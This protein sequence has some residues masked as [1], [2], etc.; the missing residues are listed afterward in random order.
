MAEFG[1]EDMLDRCLI[2]STAAVFTR[3]IYQRVGGIRLD[4]LTEDYDLWLRAMAAGG[5]HVYLPEV[6]VRY[7]VGPGQ[8]TASTER[9]YDGTAESLQHLAASGV[10][11]RHLT[12]VACTSARRYALLARYLRTVAA[13]EKFEARLCGGDV[14]HARHEFLRV[15]L[16]YSSTVKFVAATPLVMMSSRLY[17][18]YV[19]FMRARRGESSVVGERR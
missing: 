11:D 1:L 6:L 19:R 12:D 3:D 18:A 9:I 7:R 4:A 16:A 13:R 5:R 10:L 17:A 8:M 15:R 2:S 14:R